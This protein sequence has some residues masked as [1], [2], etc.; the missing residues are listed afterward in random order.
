[1]TQNIN[2]DLII[3]TEGKTDVQHIMA[4][5]RNL[6]INLNI[7]YESVTEKD[8][9]SK[10]LLRKCQTFCKVPQQIP[11]AFIFDQ[12]EEEILKEVTTKDAAYKFWGNNTFSITLPRPKH[13]DNFSD[14]CIEL[15]YTDE[16]L[17]RQDKHGTARSLKF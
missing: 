12:D 1:M 9:G 11:M 17:T 2:I 15:L 7:H 10:E 3:W 16:E 13:R 4:A 5:A 14:Y 6:G 8:G